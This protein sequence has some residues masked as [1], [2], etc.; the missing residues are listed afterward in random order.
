MNNIKSVFSI[1]DLE[2]LSGIKAHTIRI[3]EKRYQVL[4][5][6]RTGS[7]IR[8]YDTSALQKLLNISLLHRHGYKISKISRLPES[9]I[10]EMAAEIMSNKNVG[11][12]AVNAFKMAMMNFDAASFYRTYDSLLEEKPL[13]ELF[14][15][16]FIP[17]MDEIGLL[18]QTGTISPAHEHFISHLVRQKITVGTEL[19]Q[20]QPPYRDPR[21]FVLFLPEGEVH[22]IGLLYLNYELVRAGCRTIFLGA[23]LPSGTLREITRFCENPVF[24]SYFTVSPLAEKIDDY[25]RELADSVLGDTAALW[26]LG[27]NSGLIDKGALPAGVSLF[28]S[29]PKVVSEV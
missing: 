18:W 13:H 4:S 27:R 5:P 1:K 8:Y 22:E 25:V 9:R 15:Q 10:P 19:L 7:N 24:I 21:T 20:H 2:N 26:L 23:H 3:W 11:V 14:Y 29:I 28:D 16:V 17:L 12:H 6:M